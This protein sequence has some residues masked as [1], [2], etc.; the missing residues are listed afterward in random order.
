MREIKSK[1]FFDKYREEFGSISQRLVDAL[2]EFNSEV[3][4]IHD[5]FTLNEW[6]YIYATVYYET[7]FSFECVRESPKRSEEW[8]KKNFRYYPYYGRGYVQ[9]TWKWNYETF[10][11]LL[12]LDLVNKPDLALNPDTGFKILAIGC[13]RG[14][15]TGKK[16]SDYT[17]KS[18][19][20]AVG[21]RRVIN[22]TDKATLIAMHYNKFLEILKKST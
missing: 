7:A 14:L 18:G 5:W 9:I 10:S 6:A 21:A 3:V 20:D 19:F 2:N 22:S 1:V 15:F 4:Q 17:T 16:V 13:K 11:K 8:R 12:D